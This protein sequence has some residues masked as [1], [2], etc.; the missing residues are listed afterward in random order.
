MGVRF[1][2]TTVVNHDRLIADITRQIPSRVRPRLERAGRLAVEAVEAHLNEH[3]QRRAPD[4]R[5]PDFRGKP[6][7]HGSWYAE[8]RDESMRG[9]GVTMRVVLGSRADPR[10][11]AFMEKGESA[12]TI[13]PGEGKQWLVFPADES[14]AA[15]AQGGG[16]MRA[17]RIVNRSARA[18]KPIVRKAMTDALAAVTRV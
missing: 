13:E 18:G 5:H 8:V 16:P 11:V 6:H 15:Q 10:V 1:Q 4:R 7:L 12:H 17:Q 2:M 9:Q 14:P 3:F